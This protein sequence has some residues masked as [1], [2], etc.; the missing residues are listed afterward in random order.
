MG[1]PKSLV[2]GGSARA[3]V[4]S[5]LGGRALERRVEVRVAGRD[6]SGGESDLC[7]VEGSGGCGDDPSSLSAGGH[8]GVLAGEAGECGVGF[9]AVGIEQV[10]VTSAVISRAVVGQ[11]PARSF[12]GLV[13]A[14]TKVFAVDELRLVPLPGGVDHATLAVGLEP[15]DGRDSLRQS[16]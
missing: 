7:G 11:G 3:E 2:S 14:D 15:R 1:R 9:D 5:D 12:R 6:E 13:D 16:R 4:R 10:G 8:S